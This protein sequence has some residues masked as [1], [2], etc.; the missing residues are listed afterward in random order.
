MYLDILQF[1]PSFFVARKNQLRVSEK[2]NLSSKWPVSNRI[3]FTLYPLA[4]LLCSGVEIEAPNHTERFQ[5]YL[6]FS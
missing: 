6:C 3:P 1:V 5:H 2:A 4:L